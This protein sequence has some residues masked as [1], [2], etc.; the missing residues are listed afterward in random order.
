MEHKPA[1]WLSKDTLNDVEWLPADLE[2][3]ESVKCI[4]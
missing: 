2:V 1:S 3:I 4:C